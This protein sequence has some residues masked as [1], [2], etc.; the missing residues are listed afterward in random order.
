MCLVGSRWS[1]VRMQQA[2]TVV[3][4]AGSAW[5][6]SRLPPP[7]TNLQKIVPVSNRPM[8]WCKMG[9]G[10][11]E[12]YVYALAI[13]N[14]VLRHP[15]LISRWWCEVFV[16]LVMGLTALASYL[17]V[18]LC[19]QISI[20]GF[21]CSGGAGRTGRLTETREA[22]YSWVPIRAASQGDDILSFLFG[23]NCRLFGWC[24]ISLCG[25]RVVVEWLYSGPNFEV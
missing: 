21:G 8:N 4:R 19:S 15:M 24:W 2:F 23:Y 25:C 13:P 3:G 1:V 11:W 18:L 17:P 16:C 6:F 10:F 14:S 12:E 7:C 22:P 9:G 5:S 20:G